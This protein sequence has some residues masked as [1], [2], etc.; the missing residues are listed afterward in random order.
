MNILMERVLYETSFRQPLPRQDGSAAAKFAL[1]Q[2]VGQMGAKLAELARDPKVLSVIEGFVAGHRFHRGGNDL[3]AARGLMAPAA[4]AGDAEA[5][6]FRVIAAG[7][8]PVRRGA[9]WVL[10][11][12]GGALALAPVEAEA[13]GWLLARPDVTEAEL[14]AAYPAVDAGALLAR[15]AGAGLVLAG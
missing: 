2:R 1:T 8:R 7:A 10:K 11:T 3:L 14:K 15:L 4:A 6:G 5:Q 13:A 12:E 9:E